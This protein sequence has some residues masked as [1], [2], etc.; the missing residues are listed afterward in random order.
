[1]LTFTTCSWTRRILV[2]INENKSAIDFL[3][4]K[5]QMNVGGKR[6]NDF[7]FCRAQKMR[8]FARYVISK[9]VEPSVY[10]QCRNYSI[11]WSLKNILFLGRQFSGWIIY[12]HIF[13]S[14]TFSTNCCN[15]INPFS[16]SVTLGYDGV[17]IIAQTF[18]HCSRSYYKISNNVIYLNV[19]LFLAIVQFMT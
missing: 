5:V 2:K 3:R 7:F 16:L 19:F 6:L 12:I 15:K 13:I 14:N 10:K 8:K 17:R 18:V 9:A 4:Y 1:M 11:S